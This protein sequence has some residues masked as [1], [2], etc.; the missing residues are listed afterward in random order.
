M[1]ELDHKGTS[2]QHDK[3]FGFDSSVIINW[4]KSQEKEVTNM[5]VPKKDCSPMAGLK[6]NEANLDKERLIWKG[7]LD[8]SMQEVVVTVKDLCYW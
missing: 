4:E 7:Q 6:W 2:E 8:Q 1:A 5:Y 3:E